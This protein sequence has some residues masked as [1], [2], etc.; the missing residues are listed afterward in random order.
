[1]IDQAALDEVFDHNPI[2]EV[3]FEVRY[4]FNLQVQ[5]D[6]CEVQ[7]RVRDEYPKFQI[8]EVESIE[9]SP[10]KIHTFWSSDG[11]RSVRVSEDRFIIVFT[12]YE[13]F[14]IFQTEA[15]ARTEAFCDIFS[16]TQ[17]QRVGL[18]FVNNVEV[19]RENNAYQITK[20]MNPFI[21]IKRVTESGP[22][23]FSLEVT[24]RKPSC[25][26]TIRTAFAGK[27]PE[28]PGAIYL[29]DLDAYVH[30]E[31]PIGDLGKLSQE[32]HHQIQLEFL[33][34]ITEFYKG[35][36]RGQS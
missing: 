35:I 30:N 8:E 28:Q 11:T 20:I 10:A 5:R 15:L 24:M 33:G 22:M 23:R 25:L 32:L 9:G 4:P 2:K 34:H 21:D 6:L 13:T 14:E 3:A 27:P 1:M 31:I 16:I 26:L 18:R 12:K 19:P 7:K 17:F 29:L 36:M